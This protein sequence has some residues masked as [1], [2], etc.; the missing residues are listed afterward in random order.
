MRGAATSL[1]GQILRVLIQTGSIVI[2]AR[3][4]QPSEY[5]LIAMVMVIIGVG[6]IF[7]DFGLSSAAVQAPTLSDDE[8]DAL[9]WINTGLGVLLA[10]L[11]AVAAPLVALLFD[12]PALTGICQVLAL[13]FVFNGAATQYRAGLTRELRFGALVVVDVAAQIG[14]VATAISLAAAGCGVWALAIQQ[15]ATGAVMMAALLATA[16]WLPG[17]PRRGTD[18]RSF[19]TFGWYLVA[20]QL[21]GYAANNAD[22]FVIGLRLGK[23][24]LGLYN[25]AFQLLMQSYN[26]VRV[27]ITRVAVP[28]FARLQDDEIAYRR[29][30]AR[31]QLCLGYTLVVALAWV[32][33]AA[34]PVVALLLGPDWSQVAPLLAW[35]AIAA[36]F[37]TLA[38][39]GY[40]VY[41]SQ[42]LT[43]DLMRFT[44]VASAIKIT[45]VV[46]GS[47]FGLVGVAAG[48]ALAP[49]VTWPVSLW[50][51]GRC[52]GVVV[53]DLYLGALRIIVIAALS[54]GAA[55][56]AVTLTSGWWSVAQILAGGLAG[57][58]AVMV[59]ALAVRRVRMDIGEVRSAVALIRR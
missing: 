32:A 57:A 35:L 23:D 15:V 4:L 21:V 40:W 54:G 36:A 44:F 8:R 28:V 53:D 9:F 42:G 25:R 16:R 38:F 51:M 20:S 29:F 39:V 37:D 17:R 1:G 30:L 31:G 50:W 19:M 18:V 48:Y 55:W 49:A 45:C 33:G 26:L 58:A 11:L 3:L 10:V 5:G 56:V 43:R 7:R 2:L 47:W 59:A 27:P 22:T 14:G 13:T 46:T 12:E 52:A 24:P 34:E 41:V 6:E